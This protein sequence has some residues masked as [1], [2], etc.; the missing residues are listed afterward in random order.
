MVRR[1][2]L[3]LL[4]FF[5]TVLVT[6]TPCAK[7]NFSRSISSHR[8]GRRKFSKGNDSRAA[9]LADPSNPIAYKVSPSCYYRDQIA[10][11]REFTDEKTRYT[12]EVAKYVIEAVQRFGIDALHLNSMDKLRINPPSQK[13]IAASAERYMASRREILGD[14][15]DKSLASE[16]LND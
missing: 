11:C 6:N 8:I 5:L 15:A 3:R 12:D 7:A 2:A 13:D 9:F 16:P 10:R 4:S 1:Q 14:I